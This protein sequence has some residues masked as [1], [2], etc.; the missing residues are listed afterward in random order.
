M[1][2]CVVSTAPPP[3][4]FIVQTDVVAPR[5][6]TKRILVPSGDQSG[7]ASSA[8]LPAVR[9]VGSPVPSAFMVKT[10]L[11]PE[12]SESNASLVP[13]GLQAGLTSAPGGSVRFVASPVPLAF[14]TQMSK[15]SPRSLWKAIFVPSGEKAGAPFVPT[16]VSA[17]L[18]LPSLAMSQ[19]WPALSQAMRLPSGESDG[20]ESAAALFVSRATPVPAGLMV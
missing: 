1:E 5:A 4:V 3:S 17:C 9:F 20:L 15:P 18:L 8:E 10:S 11:L 13:A 6:L 7:S 19:T 2:A 12:R 16:K 14:M